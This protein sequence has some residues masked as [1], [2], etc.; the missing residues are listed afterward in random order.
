MAA[1]AFLAKLSADLRRSAWSKPNE[2]SPNKP[3][4]A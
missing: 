3:I 4:A 2:T 1:L